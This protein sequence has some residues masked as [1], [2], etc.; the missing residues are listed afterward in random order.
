MNSGSTGADLKALFAQYHSLDL[1]AGL[2]PLYAIED[3]TT[4]RRD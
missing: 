2:G 1:L 4:E 3:E